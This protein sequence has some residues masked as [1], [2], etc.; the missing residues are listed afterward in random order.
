MTPSKNEVETGAIP[1]EMSRA[2]F[3][4]MAAALVEC[5][6]IFAF[7]QNNLRKAGYAGDPAHAAV[8]Y[9]IMTSRLLD[10][11]MA[12]VI[13]A[14]SSAGKSYLLNKVADLIP[15]EEKIIK[16]AISPKALA[17]GKEPLAHKVLCIQEASG[18]GGGEGYAMLRTLLSEGHIAYE[19]TE[20]R[21]DKFETRNLERKGPVAFL[22]TT[23][24]KQL[25]HE[26]DTRFITINVVDTPDHTAQVLRQMGI[27][28]KRNEKPQDNNLEGFHA[29][30]RWLAM[31]PRKVLIPFSLTLS[32]NFETLNNRAKRDFQ[33]V[34][35]SIKV[36]ALLHQAHR[37]R[38]DTGAVVAEWQD[39]EMVRQILNPI[40]SETVGATIA[41]DIR[42]LVET[43][44]EASNSP[45]AKGVTHAD[46]RT[47]LRDKGLVRDASNIS[48]L[49]AKA[50]DDGWIEDRGMGRGYPSCLVQIRALPE[51]REA[52]IPRDQMVVVTSAT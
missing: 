47:R 36:S 20:K 26:D 28:A 38:D 7:V 18:A 21:G 33:Q 49:V 51:D 30:Q 8:I 2:E 3:R 29:Y 34:I 19:V 10:K 5:E 40:L 48:R 39:Y 44:G 46:L 22:M 4:E 11:P 17:Y 35:Q 43:I 41:A 23:T 52:L 25:H 27:A 12:G 32:G 9:L 1:T 16:S 24:L 37:Q 31:G 6:N 45:A 13:T 42:L 14:S 15:P 50:R